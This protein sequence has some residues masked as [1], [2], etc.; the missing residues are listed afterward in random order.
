MGDLT[1]YKNREGKFIARRKG[2]VTKKRIQTDPRYQRT[3][4]NLREFAEA[5][6]S[7]KF[8]KNAFREIELKSNGGKLHNRLYSAAMKVVKSDAVNSRGERK[9]DQGELSNLLGFEFSENAAMRNVLKIKP[10]VLDEP[11]SLTV[12][13]PELVPTKYLL[14]SEGSTF[15]RFSLIRAGINF[16]AQDYTTEVATIDPL[17]ITNLPA[18]AVTLS[19]PKP[20]VAGEKYFF[21]LTLEFFL[22]VN[23]NQY[24]M[25][26]I[27]QNPA[28]ILSVF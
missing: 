4:E 6:A 26:D 11:T 21:A 12:T 28:V 5:A 23:G 22:D 9:F 1:F 2:G 15:Y 7:A 25:N 16:A 10:G 24:D 19:L 17:P 27:S 20:G 18:E 13:I 14:Y 3:R 8:L